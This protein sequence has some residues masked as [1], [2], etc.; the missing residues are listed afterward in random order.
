MDPITHDELVAAAARW[1]RKQRC[2]AVLVE[3]GS[4]SW[5]EIP[6]AIGFRPNGESLLVEV[7]VSVSDLVAQF[8]KPSAGHLGMGRHRWF[9][10]PVGMLSLVQR[11]TL[12]KSWGL[13]E[14]RR[15]GT[16][17]RIVEIVPSAH[18]DWNGQA[19]AA[20]LTAELKRFAG[21]PIPGRRVGLQLMER[22]RSMK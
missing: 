3:C 21:G 7:K 4:W 22:R 16:G 14:A 11:A 2:K 10:T 13:L 9:L 17:H 15:S 1:L 6:D 12:L 18:D 8:R 20:L 19:E 5:P